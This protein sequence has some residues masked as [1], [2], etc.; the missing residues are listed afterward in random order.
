MI[1]SLRN[2]MAEFFSEFAKQVHLEVINISVF[3]QRC[4][5]VSKFQGTARGFL[6]Y[7][8]LNTC[9]LSIIEHFQ[10]GAIL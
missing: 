4:L 2:P 8:H 7:E 6:I 10:L 3:V 5:S 9:C 1:V